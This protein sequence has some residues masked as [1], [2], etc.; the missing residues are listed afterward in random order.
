M[1]LIRACRLE[2]R[3]HS[4]RTHQKCPD[5]DRVRDDLA[6]LT[7]AFDDGESHRGRRMIDAHKRALFDRSLVPETRVH[8]AN[9]ASHAPRARLRSAVFVELEAT[10][11]RG[12]VVLVEVAAMALIEPGAAETRDVFG[13]GARSN[14]ER[15]GRP[16]HDP[17]RSQLRVNAIS[18]MAQAV[19]AG[20]GL[21][22]L[23]D[24]VLEGADE[25]AV[26]LPE[27]RLPE[28]D[29]YFVYPPAL[30][31]SKRVHVFRDFLVDSARKWSY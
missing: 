26:V 28:F 30:K 7:V 14:L 6:L 8:A 12:V 22:M 10:A 25:F 13:I 17:R 23:P 19:R 1:S 21:A 4:G 9:R 3:R 5:D 16:D 15:V 27:I 29:T 24:Y 20:T 18:G 31:N 2:T 11:R